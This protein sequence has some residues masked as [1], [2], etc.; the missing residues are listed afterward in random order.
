MSLIAPLKPQFMYIFYEAFLNN[1][2]ASPCRIRQFLQLPLLEESRT[3]SILQILTVRVY[4]YDIKH[5]VQMGKAE[6]WVALSKDRRNF[7]ELDN[8]FKIL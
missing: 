8:V 1:A 3:F 5:Y 6:E 7:V 2:V 4:N